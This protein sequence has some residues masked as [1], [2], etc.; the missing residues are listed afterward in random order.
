MVDK[1]KSIG[2]WKIIQKELRRRK[3]PSTV[4]GIRRQTL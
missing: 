3:L 1:E 4:R 2:R